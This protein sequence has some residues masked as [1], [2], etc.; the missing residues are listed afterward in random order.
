MSSVTCPGL[1]RLGPQCFVFLPRTL[2]TNTV[3]TLPQQRAGAQS[4]WLGWG[5]SPCDGRGRPENITHPISVLH[6]IRGG[7]TKF[8]TAHILYL[9][10][11]HG[12]KIKNERH[13]I[14]SSLAQR[15]AEVR[16]RGA[17]CPSGRSSRS[18]SHIYWLIIEGSLEMSQH[19]PWA[20]QMGAQ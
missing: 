13:K 9:P 15:L 7:R 2:S 19:W 11:R 5:T 3:V 14:Q 12:G 1:S 18:A 4:W 17:G 20:R 16:A 6:S 10:I 8:S